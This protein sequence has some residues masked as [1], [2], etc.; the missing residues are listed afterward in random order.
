MRE[1][2]A[3]QAAGIAAPARPAFGV[4]LIAGHGLR[5]IHAQAQALADDLRLGP[6]NERRVH[7]SG[8]ALDARLG[9]Q[10][11]ESLERGDE[12]GTTVW[13]A[14]RVHHVDPDEDIARLQHFGPAEREREHH[15]VARRNISDRDSSRGRFRHLDPRVGERGAADARQIHAHDA[16]LTHP[17]R[18][19][20]AARGPQLGHVALAVI[21]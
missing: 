19:G 21:D 8:C 12:L 1:T 14:A 18:S 7:P 11:R 4:G 5:I 16:M 10:G 2:G 20:D 15:G 3:P 13:I 17:Q 6:P 9:G